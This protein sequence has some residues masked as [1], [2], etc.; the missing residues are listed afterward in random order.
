ML[1]GNIL[2]SGGLNGGSHFQALF[3]FYA[4]THSLFPTKG[5]YQHLMRLFN[6]KK[7]HISYNPIFMI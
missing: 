4:K 2:Q 3:G 7:S 5:I 1:A 6:S